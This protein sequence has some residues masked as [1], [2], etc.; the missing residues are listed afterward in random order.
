MKTK[1]IMR[2]STSLERSRKAIEIMATTRIRIKK[3]T[4]TTIISTIAKITKPEREITI[5]EEAIITMAIETI[6]K[7]METRATIVEITTN[8][9]REEVITTMAIRTTGERMGTTIK[10]IMEIL[11]KMSSLA[12]T[13]LKKQPSNGMIKLG[14]DIYNMFLLLV[15][16]RVR[17]LYWRHS[18]QTSWRSV[19]M[20]SGTMLLRE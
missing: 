19:S 4:I 7:G 16:R 6:T 10:E 13:L 18:F 1:I 12:K 5:T 9:T 2:I 20:F 17:L 3:A 15:I 8:R 14:A 11:R